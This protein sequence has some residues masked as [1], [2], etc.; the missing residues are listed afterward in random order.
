VSEADGGAT[1]NVTLSQS[2]STSTSVQIHTRGQTAQG[3]TDFYGFTKTLVFAAG[4]SQQ[5]VAITV[6]DDS[7]AESAT[8]ETLLLRL[9]NPVGLDI[10]RGEATLTIEDDD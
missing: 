3:G 8:P 1:L 6:I 2:A 5:S 4:E 7:I 10:G 9:F